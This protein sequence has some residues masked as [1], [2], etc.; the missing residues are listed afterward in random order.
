MT[1]AHQPR[2]TLPP[3]LPVRPDV[4]L[5][6]PKAVRGRLAELDAEARWLRRLLRLLNRLPAD[7]PAAGKAVAGAR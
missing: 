2:P 6:D 1:A 4:G 3:P 7:Q 5:P